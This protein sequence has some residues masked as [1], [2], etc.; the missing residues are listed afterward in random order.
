MKYISLLIALVAFTAFAQD[1]SKLAPYQYD[2]QF[3]QPLAPSHYQARVTSPTA[4][5]MRCVAYNDQTPI[6]INSV[7]VYP[8]S[9]V[10]DFYIDPEEGPVNLVKCW[11]TSSREADVEQI[12]K[13][14]A[15]ATERNLNQQ[16]SEPVPFY[17]W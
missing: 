11:I 6:A 12:E 15:E 1:L 4:V 2:Q 17:Q 3:I 5:K 8:P 16:Q 7:V 14:E 9:V 10:A 13:R